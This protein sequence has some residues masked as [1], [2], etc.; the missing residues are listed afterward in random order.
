MKKS[1]MNMMRGSVWLQA[2]ALLIMFPSLVMLPSSVRA[3][4]SGGV[5]TYGAAEIMEN[6]DNPA[7]LQIMQSSNKAIINWQDFSI[8]AGEHTQFVQPSQMAAV[9]NRVVSGNPSVLAGMLSSNGKVLVVNQNGI[10]VTPSGVID[11]AG[12]V[13]LSTLDIAD[14]DFLNG[15]DEN[16]MFTKGVELST[17]L[18][19]IAEMRSFLSIFSNMKAARQIV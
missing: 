12:G 9:L 18:Q 15:M 4:P 13:V 17:M 7:F 19:S 8:G 2:M 16:F 10:L 6:I 1:M 11:A 14:G 5:V 3:N